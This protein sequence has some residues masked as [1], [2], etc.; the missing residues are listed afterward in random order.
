MDDRDRRLIELLR[1]DARRPMVALARDLNL[2]RSATQ[3][4]LA[5]LLSSGVIGGFTIREGKGEGAK[6]SAYLM[7]SFQPGYRCAQVLPK[8]LH[9]RSIG[10]IHS[11]TGPIDLIIRVDADDVAGVESCRSA[12]AEVAGIESVSTSVVLERHLD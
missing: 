11:V 4:R 5:R 3:E 2:S 9:I 7:V 10:L 12:V 6:Q 8:L 1:R